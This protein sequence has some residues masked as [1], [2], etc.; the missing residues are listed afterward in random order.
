MSIQPPA[1]LQ[2]RQLPRHHHRR[3]AVFLDRQTIQINPAG[4]GFS[5][6]VAGIPDYL[7]T[8]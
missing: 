2:N 1:S 4:N 7:I 3:L 5:G 6:A 8:S